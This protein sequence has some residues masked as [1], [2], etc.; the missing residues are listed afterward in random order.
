MF[1]A[2]FLATAV[3]L[4]ALQAPTTAAAEALTILA[5]DLPPM[6]NGDGSGR[7]AE[8]ISSV[9][10]RCGHTVTFEIQ[11][12]TRHWKSYAQGKGDA[13]ATVPLGM[14]L[15]GHAT[16]AYIQYQNGV[17][18]LAENGAAYSDLSALS[19][20]SVIAFMGASDI[21]P[22]LKDAVPAFKSY[23]EIA[24]QIGQSRMIFGQRVD[25]VIGDG[26]IFAE[27]NRQLRDQAGELMFDP[28]QDVTFQA[29][30]APSDYGMYFRSEAL[31]A[32]FNRCHAEAVAD[33]SLAAI[34][35]AWAD[36]YRDTLGDQYLGH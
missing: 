2:T 19:G 27:Y 20:Q 35:R 7:E 26:M 3:T 1:K 23:K 8:V 4:S 5:G 34:N 24:D 12:F 14:P 36:R 13:V 31:T 22:G 15:P 28:N 29:I 18:S 9:M 21:I 16:E 6:F 25:A 10:E 11:P 33:G 17:S 32:D 30:F